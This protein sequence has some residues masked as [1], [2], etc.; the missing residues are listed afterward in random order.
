MIKPVNAVGLGALCWLLTACQSIPPTQANSTTTEP[1][2]TPNA[3][4]PQPVRGTPS[5]PIPA[6][7]PDISESIHTVVVSDVPLR[8]LL[9]SL[10]RD[11]KLDLDLDVAAK[12]LVTINAIRQPLSLIL[13][14]IVASNDLRYSIKN[15]VLKIEKDTPF[16]RNYAVDYLNITRSAVG[17]VS[18]STQISA[19]GQ[20]A[21]DTGGESGSGDNNSSTKVENISEHNFWL[22]LE[23]NIA[24]VLGATYEGE[25]HPD[26]F[27]NRGAG[28]VGVRANSRKH[29]EIQQL[30][31]EIQNSSQRQVLIEATIAEVTLN[32]SFQAGIDW[33]QVSQDV[34]DAWSLSQNMTDISLFDRPSFNFTVNR[35]KSN[36]DS[37][38]GTL[39]ALETFGDVRVMSSPKIMAMNNQTAL[40]KVVDNLVY[41]TVDVNID[42]G[43][44]NSGRL[45]TYESEIHTVPVGFVMGVTPF[46]SEAGEVTLNVRP[47]I[48]RVIGQQRDPNPALAEANVVS[49]IPIIQVREVESILK[50]NSGDVAVIGGLMQDEKKK[51]SRGVPGISRIPY[52][53]SL[54]KYQDDNKNKTELVIFIK[55]VVVRQ[56][57]I[58]KDLRGFR[59]FYNEISA[60]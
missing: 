11:A 39:S 7:K 60:H 45:Y 26:I 29:R 47:T 51:T 33:S 19:T 12:G 25:T 43:D 9:F 46:V 58:D 36:G 16:I 17:K 23:N 27:L 52:V 15:S 18:V 44:D 13:E 35:D 38:Q 31:D 20:G 10:A 41:F 4:I 40:L 55:P 2:K 37:L 54:F 24:T 57:S 49:E 22:A 3:A 34:G 30:I 14:R 6:S 59:K 42:E 56:A 1:A 53:G 28:L 8:E 32:D 5:L 21:G 48:S 50:V